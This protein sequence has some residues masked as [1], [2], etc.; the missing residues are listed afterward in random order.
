MSEWLHGA[1]SAPVRPYVQVH[2]AT[3]RAVDYA[4]TH[5]NLLRHKKIM[6]AAAFLVR[7]SR[8]RLLNGHT[9]YKSNPIL[10]GPHPMPTNT[11]PPTQPFPTSTAPP[12]ARPRLEHVDAV[13]LPRERVELSA[14]RLVVRLVLPYPRSPGEAPKLCWRAAHQERSDALW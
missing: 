12:A 7:E 10:H 14:V 8:C 1:E 3:P 13:R 9:C 6:H 11:P 5:K 4:S 2:R